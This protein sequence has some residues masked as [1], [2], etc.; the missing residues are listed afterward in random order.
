M[1]RGWRLA[2]ILAVGLLLA[3][4]RPGPAA[5]E[6]VNLKLAHVVSVNGAY[7]LG[8]QE[9]ARL[10]GLKTQGRLRITIYPNGVLGGGEKEII[11][12]MQQGKIDLVVTSTGP[13]G[14]MVP[15]M[16]ICDLP[17]LFRNTD[18]ADRVLDGGIGQL[19]MQDLAGV[20]IKGVAFWENGFRH[21]TNSKR[22]VVTPEDMQGLTLRTMENEIHQDFFR[23]LG[24]KPVPLPW[25][26]VYR[27]LKNKT[28]DGQENPIAIIVSEK[29]YKVNRYLTLTR[30]VYSPALLMM[31]AKT[32]EGLSAEDRQAI[33]EAGR[34]AAWWERQFVR[35]NEVR[36]LGELEAAG[37]VVV[38]PDRAPF[39]KAAQAVYKTYQDRIGKD[40]L[41]RIHRVK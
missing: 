21:L 3:S 40:L 8:A 34:E 26:K 41:R 23:Q 6:G 28:V 10:V 27:A 4:L 11:E 19:L 15:Q 1:K 30:H 32:F 5:A 35:E 33:L 17:Y 18:H 25:G 12:G 39:R 16:A 20:G 7:H 38:T 36:M 24:A 14:T 29:I 9:F 31:N 22:V 37:M 13:I 2:G